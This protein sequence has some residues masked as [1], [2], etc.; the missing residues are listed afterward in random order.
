LKHRPSNKEPAVS[1]N[2]EMNPPRKPRWVVMGTGAA[3]L[4]AILFGVGFAFGWFPQKPESEAES[5]PHASGASGAPAAASLGDL[6]PGLEAKVAANPQD[7]DQ[8]MLLAQ[9][10]GELGQRDKSIKELRAVHKAAPNNTQATV[11]LGA[12][13]MQSDAQKDLREAYKLLDEAVRVKAAVAPMARLYQGEILVKLGDSKG[14]AKI[15][16]D[17]VKQM[18]AGDPRR[19]MFEERIA[20]LG[21]AR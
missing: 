19:G 4:V 14:A 5:S 3:I 10:Y 8:R 13:L 15:W 12:A 1:A 21:A 6:L 20:Q 9:T 17:Y 16:R 11:L 7:I 2:L 18:P